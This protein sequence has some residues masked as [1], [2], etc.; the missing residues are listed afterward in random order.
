M[1]RPIQR[2]AESVT[3]STSGAGEVDAV[4]VKIAKRIIPL[5]GLLFV[6]AWL[7]RYNLGFAKL[8]MVK[9]LGFN[10]AVFGFGAGIVYLGYMLF[11]VPSNLFLERIGARKTFA[12][13]TILW[14]ITSIA[15]MLVKTATWF[16]ILRFLL[17]SFEAGLFP[18]AVLYL[19]YW[20]PA[21]RR[22][23][24]QAL[25]SAS[26]PISV[27]IGGPI[28][29]WI[30]NS[31]SGRVGLANWQWLFLL[32]GVP[33]IAV[34]LLALA[35]VV[36]KPGQARWLTEREKQLVLAD[37][38]A[39]RRKAGPRP[40]G[41]GEALKVPQLWL[42]TAIYFCAT[43]ANVTIGFWVPTIIRGLGVKSYIMIGLLS[44]V[45]YMGGLI[46]MILVSRH[47]DRTLERR[48]HCA[49]PCLACA[50]G[51]IGIGLFANSPALAFAALVV[52]VASP[53]SGLQAFW[54]MPPTLL[55][56][57][58]A[59]GGI[60]L[61]NSVGNVSGWLGPSVVG[62]LEDLT[63]KIST[64]LYVVAGL[65]VLASALILRFMP[66]GPVQI[67]G[68]APDERAMPQLNMD[69]G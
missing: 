2:A 19:T 3:L 18:G 16:Y 38:E 8:Q 37:L 45:P 6:M 62:W 66:C 48:Y 15:M 41:F 63:G 46:G 27:I 44:T 54:T 64:G 58:A 29:G 17:G 68:K 26:I 22:A 57:A 34:G 49:V 14:G 20:F 60:A 5:L 25:F 9:D 23:M 30:M 59:A 10:E 4:Y 12:R 67:G 35:I 65:E 52:A 50:V 53:L 32:E 40:H 56:G 61:I 31:M 24:M 33:S 43:S 7:D 36:D 69:R 55:S 11:E 51:L 28:S 21:R 1:K 39:D 42:L 47:S 13:V